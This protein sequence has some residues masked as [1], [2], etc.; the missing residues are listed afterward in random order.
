MQTDQNNEITEIYLDNAATTKVSAAAAASAY[1]CMLKQYGNPSSLHRKGLEAE[2]LVANARAVFSGA[3]SCRPEEIYFTAGSTESTLIAVHG[4]LAAKKH[5]G[6]RIVTTG[7]EHS[8]VARTLSSLEKSGYEIAVVPPRA[9]GHYEAE[10]FAAAV[11]D[12][13]VLITAMQVNNETGLLLPIERIGK[14]CKQRHPEIVFHVDAT[15]A[16]G[17]MPLFPHKWQV[18]MMSFSGHKIHAPKG[19]GALYLKSGLRLESPITGGGQE[20]G[21]R[22]GTHNVPGIVGFAVALQEILPQ[23]E[24]NRKRYEGFAKQLREELSDLP[25]V[26]FNSNGYCVPWIVNLSVVG[27]RSEILLHFLEERGIYVS[28]GSAC[29]VGKKSS[30]LQNLALSD[31]RADSALRV[32]FSHE[33]TRQQIKAF[34]AAIHEAVNSLAKAK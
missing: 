21:I 15:Q 31:A 11:D 16:L 13:T 9:D 5:G 22:S 17:K 29:S 7:I 32:S 26:V 10:D 27:Y 3:L 34:T 4:L 14:L 24:Q 18:D 8:A 12:N 33:T 1:S 19:V 30:V 2:K 6:K 25:Q 28:S 20:S 23:M